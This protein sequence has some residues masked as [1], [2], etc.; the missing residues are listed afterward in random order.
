MRAIFGSTRS[1]YRRLR[2][3]AGATLAT[4][5]R[6]DCAASTGSHAGTEAMLLSATAGIWLEGTFCHEN[7]KI[8]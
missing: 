8:R 3:E 7:S 5:G 1:M 2:G 6:E 4:T